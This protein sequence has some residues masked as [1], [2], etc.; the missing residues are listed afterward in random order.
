M[1]E[2]LR[3]RTRWLGNRLLGFVWAPDLHWDW[4]ADNGD[5]H[6][7]F[8]SVARVTR[9]DLSFVRVTLGPVM[10]LFGGK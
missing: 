2:K 3:A 4:T 7:D 10:L 6:T 8:V 9:G 5:K 1:A